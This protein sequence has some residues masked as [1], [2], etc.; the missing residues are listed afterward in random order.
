MW[1]C[2]RKT[3]IL[4]LCCVCLRTRY[5]QPAT[6]KSTSQKSNSESLA[7]FPN[8]KFSVVDIWTWLLRG[9][10]AFS[11][12]LAAYRHLHWVYLCHLQ[13]SSLLWEG[14]HIVSVSIVIAH[15]TLIISIHSDGEAL[16]LSTSE[17]PKQKGN[18]SAHCW[19]QTILTN[20]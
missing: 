11:S 5:L 17:A 16:V 20:I 12:N 8:P 1:R 10:E 4:Q 13:F 3:N 14:K 15:F 9:L 7:R 6:K 19:S 18:Q 2:S